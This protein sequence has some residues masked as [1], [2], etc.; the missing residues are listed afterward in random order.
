[1][2][3]VG[4]MNRR[5]ET[6]VVQVNS[7]EYRLPGLNGQPTAKTSGVDTVTEKYLR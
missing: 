2:V 5:V 6:L 3:S 1:M 7:T 4:A